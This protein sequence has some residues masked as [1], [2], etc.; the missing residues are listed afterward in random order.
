MK[1]F[2][3]SESHLTKYLKFQWQNKAKEDYKPEKNGPGLAQYF[4]RVN[5]WKSWSEVALWYTSGS[6][7]PLGASA[8]YVIAWSRGLKWVQFLASFPCLT[9]KGTHKCH[10]AIQEHIEGQKKSNM[11]QFCK[12]HCIA[13]T[14]SQSTSIW[15]MIEVV[16][17]YVMAYIVKNNNI[18]T[19]TFSM[20]SRVN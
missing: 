5:R 14:C 4:V 20:P 3:I 1:S 9:R 8:T 2:A 17:N 7:L 19:C 6:L 13:K 12:L 15:N 18:P 11:M 10:N 16:S